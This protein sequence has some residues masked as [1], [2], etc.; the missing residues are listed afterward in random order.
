MTFC[1]PDGK[2]I[3][4][5]NRLMHIASLL[6]WCRGPYLLFFPLEPSEL[7][8]PQ[9]AQGPATVLLLPICPC[10]QGLSQGPADFLE[11]QHLTLALDTFANLTAK[12]W[13]L[14][15]CMLL[16]EKEEVKMNRKKPTFKKKEIIHIGWREP[17]HLI[18]NLVLVA[19]IFYPLHARTVILKSTKF[20]YRSGFSKACR[21]WE[22]GDASA[23][24]SR[25]SVNH[26]I[27]EKKV[28]TNIWTENNY[29]RNK[30]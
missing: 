15:A 12:G 9:T 4:A 20:V 11:N 22:K 17:D 3:H 23:W 29:P 27:Q 16:W 5:R 1:N 26:F 13:I 10:F 30:V 24:P 2:W 18:F 25:G 21:R 6:T 19:S 14:Y 7:H 28:L 8:S